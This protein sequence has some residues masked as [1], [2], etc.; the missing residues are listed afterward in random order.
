MRARPLTLLLLACATLL[1]AT[2]AL[3]STVTRVSA[4]DLR[5][6]LLIAVVDGRKVGRVSSESVAQ[7]VAAA[8]SVPVVAASSGEKPGQL[9]VLSVVISNHGALLTWTVADGRGDTRHVAHG[10]TPGA[11]VTRI[12]RVVSDMAVELTV[13][14]AFA[15]GDLVDPYLPLMRRRLPSPWAQSFAHRH[16]RRLHLDLVDAFEEPAHR[17]RRASLPN[18]TINPWRAR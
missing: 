1:I 9:G 15:E 4:Q 6:K 12:A 18:D 14:S 5:A 7:S 8:L 10:V 17:T 16:R 11:I 2:S 13:P 3:T